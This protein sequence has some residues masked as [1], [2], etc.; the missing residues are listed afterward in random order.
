[1]DPAALTRPE[2]LYVVL[3]AIAF[4]LVLVVLVVLRKGRRLP[5]QHVFRASRLS[6]GNRLLPAQVVITPESITL[7]QPQWVGKQEASI[8]LSHVASITIDTNLIFSDIFIETTGGRNPIICHG[9]RK[10]DAVAIKRII[11]QLQSAHYKAHRGT[12]NAESRD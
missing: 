5:G 7:F 3:G 8:H 12:G 4:V 2:W 9:H 6:K 11:E 1:M 10:R